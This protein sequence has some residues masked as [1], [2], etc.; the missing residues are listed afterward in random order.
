MAQHDLGIG[1]DIDQQHR[2]PGHHVQLAE[3]STSGIRADMPADQ[4]QHRNPRGFGNAQVEAP[5]R[6]FKPVLDR[7][8]EGR[9][10]Q[11]DRINPQEQVMHDRVADQHDLKDLV[12][13]KVQLGAGVFEHP[14]D[15]L[16]HL[17][18]QPLFAALVHHHV[19][20]PAHQVFAVTDLRVHCR[21]L[22]DQRAV[23]QI[24]EI[25][26]QAGRTDV[27]RCAIG[28]EG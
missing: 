12:R 10:P 16:A 21:G 2:A 19:G 5:G 25:E 6:S 3:V 13:P 1:A 14:S 27:D 11:L 24:V 4:R 9:L 20:D 22:V 26:R 23:G 8:C 17:L 15:R 18:G 7:Q 28:I